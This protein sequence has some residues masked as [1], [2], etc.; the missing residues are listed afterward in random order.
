MLLRAKSWPVLALRVV[1]QPVHFPSVV[2]LLSVVRNDDA[3]VVI[4]EKVLVRELV[5]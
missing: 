1:L 2:T 3:W 4:K 5:L